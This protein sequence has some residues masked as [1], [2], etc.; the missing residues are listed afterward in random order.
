MSFLYNR[1][2][3]NYWL[4]KLQK[5]P[6]ITASEETN[7]AADE[8]LDNI[9]EDLGLQDDEISGYVEP[10][11]LFGPGFS[12]WNII[13]WRRDKK[14]L[15]DSMLEFNEYKCE[16][17]SFHPILGDEVVE[18]N[19]EFMWDD[20]SKQLMYTEEC[21]SSDNGVE[22][23]RVAKSIFYY[24][25]SVESAKKESVGKDSEET[26]SEPKKENKHVVAQNV[27]LDESN[28]GIKDSEEPNIL[29]DPTFSLWNTICEW[30]P[31]RVPENVVR[32]HRVDE[33]TWDDTMFDSFENAY[34][35]KSVPPN[36]ASE[37][38][39]NERH[40]YWNVDSEASYYAEKW[41]S[42]QICDDDA[43]VERYLLN[44]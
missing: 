13:G 10:E 38:V 4:Q 37:V 8:E 29:P 40:I 41:N 16:E 35:E 28:S 19:R 12:I 43:T 26:H 20:G 17:E 34:E 39:D 36:L 32:N 31:K 30:F 23:E 21:V 11:F 2:V 22:L 5:F 24:N 7:N 27:D 18:N 9:E 44:L 33:T 3:L 1:A 14:V 15:D 42:A 25:F 6:Q